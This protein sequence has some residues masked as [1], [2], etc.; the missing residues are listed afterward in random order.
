MRDRGGV[1]E[2]TLGPRREGWVAC[3]ASAIHPLDLAAELLGQRQQALRVIVLFRTR[4]AGN[5][6]RE[7]RDDQPTARTECIRVGFTFDFE[8]ENVRSI[9]G[10]TLSGELG[11]AHQYTQ[12]RIRSKWQH[13]VP[14]NILAAP[15]Q[16]RDRGFRI[17]DAGEETGRANR[18]VLLWQEARVTRRLR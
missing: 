15:A 4:G 11:G 8:F 18:P 3:V 7:R 1:V 5:E 2:R 10:S 9:H 16:R 6:A 14:V 17:G 13:G 12:A